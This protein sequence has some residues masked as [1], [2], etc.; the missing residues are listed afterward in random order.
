MIVLAL[1]VAF[2]L[3]QEPPDRGRLE[4]SLLAPLRIAWKHEIAALSFGGA[5]AADVD[6]DGGLEIA[7]GAY[8]G[9]SRA[10]LL[11]GT[12]G[13]EIWS[14]DFGDG[15]GKACLDA[16]FRFADLDRDGELELLVP[17]SNRCALHAL[18]ARTGRTIWTYE[19]GRGDCIDSPP[20]LV[21][22]PD[23]GTWI[24]FG[25]F[26]GRIHVVDSRGG[27]VKHVPVGRGYVQTGPL[28]FDAD[29]DGA[30]DFVAGIF[31]GGNGLYCRSGADGSLLWSVPLPRE[32]PLDLGIYHG[33]ATGDLDGDGRPELVMTS[34][35]GIVRCVDPR[36]G[37]V[38]W[39]V[40]TGDRYF[41][42]PPAIGD[43]D[44]DGRLE[45]V[46]LS[47]RATLLS[48]KGQIRWSV[49]VSPPGSYLAADRGPSL[50]D[51]DGDGHL[52]VAGL[53]SDGWFFVLRGK[54]GE[55]IYEMPRVKVTPR[56]V[57]SCANGPL[58]ADL[59]GDGRLD[60]FMVL[61]SPIEKQRFGVAVLLKGFRGGGAGW[62]MLRHDPSNT[63]NAATRLPEHGGVRA[64]AKRK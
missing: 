42:A 48:G 54:T 38:E 37:T 57:V 16:S 22:S 49:P 53:R 9:D 11:R 56:P 3:P 19:T 8:F 40:E 61:G 34:Y 21:A 1:A 7:F 5:C 33:P 47:Q 58:I 52:D 13:S 14:R 10:R 50:A 44:G 32:K 26:L 6:G 4:R 29:G 59:D 51:L 27:L 15:E 23:G 41:M 30:L 62:T 39:K 24:A 28:A 25:S 60:A 36:D 18:D 63:G 31:K 17:V 43:V 20:L 64:G 35:D 2:A 46:A 12:D 55:L 45:V